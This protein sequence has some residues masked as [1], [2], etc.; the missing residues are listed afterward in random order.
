MSASSVA[1]GGQ[2]YF[3]RMASSIL[4]PEITTSFD[5][6]L[7]R[8]TVLMIQ[9][10][11]RCSFYE[12][13]GKIH[14]MEPILVGDLMNQY[15]ELSSDGFRVL[16]V[17]YKHLEPRSAYSKDDESE[18]I[19]KGYVA[20]LDPPKETAPMAIAAL[21]KIGVTVKV[22]TG[23]NDLVTRKICHEVDLPV[24]QLVLGS[25]V[26]TMTD[27]ELIYGRWRQ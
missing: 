4:G 8:F 24:D 11:P 1:T 18:L 16:A 21:R 13:E 14:P 9:F 25:Q 23:D 6:G 19:L 7:H 2:T 17:A 20:F 5:R 12:L 10:F 3:G 22:L 27:E 15:Q 26:E